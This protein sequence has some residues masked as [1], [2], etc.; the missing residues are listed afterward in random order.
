MDQ[1]SWPTRGVLLLAV[2]LAFGR[3]LGNQFV[4]W[5]DDYLILNNANLRPPTAE[6]LWNHW[7]QPHKKMYIPAVYTVWWT[8][9]HV[10]AG[11]Q[12]FNSAAFHGANLLA[13]LLATLVVYEIVLRLIGSRWAACAGAL[14]FAVHPLQT[15]AVAWATGMKDVLSGLLALLAIWQ[16]LGRRKW[17]Y[18]IATASLLLA[19]LAKP[20]TVMV[21]LIC[22]VLDLM[23]LHR[24]FRESAARLAPWLVLSVATA[25]LAS[26]VQMT[27]VSLNPPG[28][29]LRPLIASDSLAWYLIK[30]L[31][32]INLTI[33]YSRT[34]G[35]VI[36]THRVYWTWLIPAVA[37]ALLLWKRKSFVIVGAVIFVLSLLPLLGLTPFTFQLYSTVADRYVY[38][39][40]LGAAIVLA[41]LM[42]SIPR[43]A[44]IVLSVVMSSL[45]IALSF[46][47]AGVWHDTFTL[48]THTETIN[49][50]SLA[51]NGGL[52]FYWSD[53]HDDARAA[54]YFEIQCDKHPDAAVSFYNYA[55]LLR[56]RGDLNAA[57]EHYARA[58]EIDPSNSVY[59]VNYGVVLAAVGRS[60][61]ALDAFQRAAD[62]DPG[63]ADAYQNAG[64]VLES[65]GAIAPA[66]AAF[67]EALRLDP[68]RAVAAQHLRR[69]SNPTVG[70][71]SSR[72]P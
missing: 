69:L 12:K 29:W 36:E 26:K 48:F 13:H 52:A 27:S 5:D 30:L 10:P 18:V 40:M 57:I 17:N 62:V 38:V 21:P 37:G 50:D 35:W 33:D 25:I 8:L 4:A 70:A 6:G 24:S 11:E 7:R 49:P 54:H 14:I 16:Y 32:P 9:A 72:Q 68:G 44:A 71:P 19:L 3:V 45:W 34:P 20:S 22:A 41:F 2:L 15:E 1:S 55:N 42:Q 47:Q 59:F 67:S 63:N 65:T 23:V 64:L 46:Q 61:D 43:Q 56:R 51:S 53:H 58:I 60:G 39:A 66:R 31:V 28:L